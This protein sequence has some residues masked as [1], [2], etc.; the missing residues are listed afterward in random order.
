[1]RPSTG[2]GNDTPLIHPSG[3]GLFLFFQDPFLEAF[4]PTWRESIV[5]SI[6]S[7]PSS[8]GC[9]STISKRFLAEY[10]CR[11]E[12]E[13]G[14]LRPVVKEVVERYLDCGN[15]HCG[16]ARIRCPASPTKGKS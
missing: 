7:G 14:F 12:R 6:R 11:L 2:K 4:L 9:C 15:P 10:E 13:Y 1:M 3:P 16:F 8:A 5:P